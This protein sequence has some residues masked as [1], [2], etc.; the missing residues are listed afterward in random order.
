MNAYK[1][2]NKLFII[3]TLALILIGMTVFGIFGFNQTVDYSNGYEV[4]VSVDQGFEGATD[5]LAKETNEYFAQNGIKSKNYAFQE[6]DEGSLLIYKFSDK[7]PASIDGLESYLDAKLADADFTSVSADVEVN[8]VIGNKKFDAGM[9]TIAL[10]LGV[11]GIFIFALIMEKVAVAV[12]TIGSAVV[13]F[14][15]FL[16][17]IAILRIPAYPFVGV[18]LALS[19]AISSLMSITSARVMR[20]T[21]KSKDKPNAKQ[22]ADSVMDKEGK[23]YLFILIAFLVAGVAISAL[24]VPY[25]MIVG[26]QLVIL[27][28]VSVVSAYFVT[29]LIWS[30]IKG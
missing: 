5:I 15:L 23:K 9:L 18:G 3:I 1:S 20:L 8:Q 16:S 12:A 29:P 24:F 14:L 22:I 17:L 6:A 13:S 27:G 30:A 2:K 11:L 19:V 4:R 7:V 25:M 10:C 26:A 28:L 21:Y